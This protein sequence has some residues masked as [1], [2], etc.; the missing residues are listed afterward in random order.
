[1]KY[2]SILTI[3]LL[4]VGCQTKDDH[5]LEAAVLDDAIEESISN[6]VD[7]F[8]RT[9]KQVREQGDR[10]DDVKIYEKAEEIIKQRKKVI[11]PFSPNNE[12]KLWPIDSVLSYLDSIEKRLG[13][14][15]LKSTRNFIAE[16]VKQP[17]SL[18]NRIRSLTQ[19]KEK[20]SWIEQRVVYLNILQLEN[21]ILN[22]FAASIGVNCW[23][24][25]FSMP[26]NRFPNQD[27]ISISQSY[28][29]YLTPAISQPFETDLTFLPVTCTLEG[30]EVPVKQ[31]NVEG[32]MKITFA[33]QLPGKYKFE[34]KFKV[35]YMEVDHEYS[36]N[37]NNTIHVV[38]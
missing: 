20:L 8:M 22:T 27:T 37:F 15:D 36:L 10:S 1:M 18:V 28:T 30:K 33:P 16:Q 11:M 2:L 4:T 38:E 23:S 13:E 7:V 5:S 6:N 19:K 25:F 32:L 9:L 17:E 12:V 21:Q 24:N 31:E 35:E 34:G 14:F 26:Y 29:F 3:L